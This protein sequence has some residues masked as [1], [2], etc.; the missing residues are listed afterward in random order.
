MTSQTGKQR[1]ITHILFNISRVKANQ[2]MK[3]S[4]LTEHPKTN[5]FLSKLCRKRG[6]KTSSRPLFAF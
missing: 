5:I 2:T 3:F 4:Q 1:I 6:R